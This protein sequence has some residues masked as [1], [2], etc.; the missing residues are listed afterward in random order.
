MASSLS[1]KAEPRN[2]R[3]RSSWRRKLLALAISLLVSLLLGEV[4]LRLVGVKP[5]Y[6]N[7]EQR[8]F[9]QYHSRLGWHHRP[10][11]SGRFAKE[12]FDTSVVINQHGLRDRDYPLDRVDGMRRILVLGDSFTW[13]FGV[14]QEQV[15]TEVIESSEQ[16]LEVINAGVSG[17]SPDQ[18]LIWLRETGMRFQPDLVLLVLSGNDVWGNH[19]DVISFVYGKPRYRLAADGVLHLENVPVPKPRT[20][21]SVRHW[22]R[23]RSS[24]AQLLISALERWRYRATTPDEIPRLESS[25][26]VD[27]QPFPLTLALIREIE[28]VAA[29]GGARLAIVTNSIYWAPWPDGNYSDFIDQLRLAN[30][31]VLDIDSLPGYEK[32]RLQIPGDRHWNVEGHQLVG[33]GIQLWIREN[34]LLAPLPATR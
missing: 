20:S 23:Q 1:K 29:A 25:D 31:S 34:Q 5:L 7:P 11:Q 26:K 19:Q 27:R 3:P 9:W 12:Q 8:T 18:E 2:K 24:I 28:Q 16:G 15:F 10:G 4:V 14:E 13:G 33:R 6:V 32:S 22:L 17:Y 30:Y 21:V